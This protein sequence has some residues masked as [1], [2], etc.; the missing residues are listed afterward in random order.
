MIVTDSVAVT[1]RNGN[2]FTAALF[3]PAVRGQ[4]GCVYPSVF[5]HPQQ[6][7]LHHCLCSTF[8]H[9]V[10]V[11]SF[12]TSP[13]AF[14]FIMLGTLQI[15]KE[16]ITIVCGH[17][18]SIHFVS[19]KSGTMK[20]LWRSRYYYYKDK[21]QVYAIAAQWSWSTRALGSSLAEVNDGGWV[22]GEGGLPVMAPLFE[23]LGPAYLWAPPEN[24]F[25]IKIVLS[26]RPGPLY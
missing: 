11:H 18:S 16:Q 4:M 1:C 13:S 9:L 5:T 12:H 24:C 2:L 25:L 22:G 3:S 15:T 10:A 17:Q 20:G 26:R 21:D 7:T 6:H 19:R 8:I 14:L 23:A